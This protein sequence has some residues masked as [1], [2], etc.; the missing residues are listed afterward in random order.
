MRKKFSDKATNAPF[1]AI[2][3]FETRLKVGNNYN[4]ASK[5]HFFKLM[6]FYFTCWPK[7]KWLIIKQFCCLKWLFLWNFLKSTKSVFC[8]LNIFQFKTYKASFVFLGWLDFLSN[9]NNVPNI[10]NFSKFNLRNFFINPGFWNT[11][12]TFFL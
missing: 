7:C 9:N 4:L 12:F 8:A 10:L 3:S 5:T 6:A 2:F 11:F 1:V